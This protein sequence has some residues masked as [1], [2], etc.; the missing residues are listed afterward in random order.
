MLQNL[1]HASKKTINILIRTWRSNV[2][3]Y[4]GHWISSA[5][6]TDKEISPSVVTQILLRSLEFRCLKISA[7]DPD[8]IFLLCC[9]RR[10]M[11]E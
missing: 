5:K 2:R 9:H 7:S 8:Q 4:F 1:L 6:N 10:M 11:A 3:A